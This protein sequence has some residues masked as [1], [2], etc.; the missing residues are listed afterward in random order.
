MT[1]FS[2]T[3][4]GKAIVFTSILTNFLEVPFLDFS[5]YSY[6]SSAFE[7]VQELLFLFLRIKAFTIYTSG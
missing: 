5:K 4:F 1:H 7:V 6:V 3:V 2:K